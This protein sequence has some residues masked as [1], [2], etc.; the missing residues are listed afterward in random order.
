MLV[1]DVMSRP[2]VTVP[3]QTSVLSTAA[4]LS[5]H[6]YTALPVVDDDGRL[7]GVVTEADLLRGRL[8]H[9]P[10]SPLLGA[11]LDVP[12][13]PATVGEVMSRDVVTVVP[14]CDLA[15]AAARM[16]QL[17][18][19]SLP[20]VDAGAVVGIVTR[21]DV[22]A[23]LARAD[24]AITQEVRR[25]L[26][27]YGGPGRWAVSAADGLV[28]L[29]DEYDDPAERHSA[30]VIASAVRGVQGVRVVPLPR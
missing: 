14:W 25:R 13:P 19:R 17:G 28:T 8:H 21:R 29:G 16:A 30:R 7:V 27:S 3:P 23:T 10:R 11:E 15:D 2:V 1:R 5:G 22:V 20:V 18:L 9:D 4:L 12:L 6:G 26:E 24:A